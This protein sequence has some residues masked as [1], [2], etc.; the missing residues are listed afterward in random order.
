MKNKSGL[1]NLGCNFPWNSQQVS[2]QFFKGNQPVNEETKKIAKV[3]KE[4]DKE[5]DKKLKN[6]DSEE[7]MTGFFDSLT[8]T[9]TEEKDISLDIESSLRKAFLEAEKPNDPIKEKVNKNNA[10]SYLNPD[11]D[12]SYLVVSSFLEKIAGQNHLIK[13]VADLITKDKSKWFNASYRYDKEIL[14]NRLSDSDYSFQK[15][16]K[17]FGYEN[18]KIIQHLIPEIIDELESASVAEKK[19]ISAKIKALESERARRIS[20]VDSIIDKVKELNSHTKSQLKEIKENLINK[21]NAD[22]ENLDRVISESKIS[23]MEKN[24]IE[25]SIVGNNRSRALPSYAR[26]EIKED[27]VDMSLAEYKIIL[28]GHEFYFTNRANSLIRKYVTYVLKKDINL[29]KNTDMYPKYF[30]STYQSQKMANI[31][32]TRKIKESCSI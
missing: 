24:F 9:K 30:H 20:E 10:S 14:M 18:L 32:L 12:F 26:S 27:D 1:A 28:D 17:A 2:E 15:L 22:Y 31:G 7:Y 19:Q 3:I 8:S 6:I 16:L 23:P 5:T 11:N 13:C 21:I 4:I 25:H 29:F